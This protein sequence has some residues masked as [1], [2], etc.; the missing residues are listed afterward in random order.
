MANLLIYREVAF[1]ILKCQYVINH[2]ALIRVLRM[3]NDLILDIYLLNLSVIMFIHVNWAFW[4]TTHT[5]WLNI[6]Q[7]IFKNMVRQKYSILTRSTCYLGWFNVL[8]LLGVFEIVIIGNSTLQ[9]INM[10]FIFPYNNDNVVQSS[11][12]VSSLVIMINST[13]WDWQHIATI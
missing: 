10:L 7:S 12:C 2:D 5:G 8:C 6:I 4:S 1:I 9:N 3:F 11:I 13:F